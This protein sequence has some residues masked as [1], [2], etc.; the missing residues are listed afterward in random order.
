MIMMTGPLQDQ[1]QAGVREQ[2][3]GAHRANQPDAY[4]HLSLSLTLSLAL[5]LFLYFCI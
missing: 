4:T 3:R 2:H 5:S 1:G